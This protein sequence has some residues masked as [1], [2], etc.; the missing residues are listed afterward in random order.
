MQFLILLLSIALSWQAFPGVAAGSGSA[1]L[2]T[3][4]GS[5]VLGGSESTVPKAAKKDV[6]HTMLS[7]EVQV[8]IF[9]G[10]N[11]VWPQPYVLGQTR[12]YGSGRRAPKLAGPYLESLIHKYAGLY[13]VD[14]SLVRAVM[15]HESGFNPHAV[16]P[17][18]AQGLMQLMPG[19]AAQM[20]VENPFDPEQ[21]IAGG[22]GYLRLCLDRFDQSVPLAVAAYNAGP[23]RVR[24]WIE[25]YGDPRSASVDVVDW[26]ETIP[27][28]ETR[29]YVM[30]V[31]ESLPN[32][33]ARLTGETGSIRFTEE[34]KRR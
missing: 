3:R 18:G 17:K 6:L 29:T 26:I 7:R 9:R 32:Y 31:T 8:Y 28:E 12:F 19:T 13:G 15:R 24:Q 23:G 22:V 2:K 21:N 20:G 25:R 4:E 34:L 11:R 33:R 30:R 1:L 27:F 5:L 14:P 10:S 16:S